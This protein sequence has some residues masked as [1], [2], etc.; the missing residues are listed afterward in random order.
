MISTAKIENIVRHI[1]NKNNVKVSDVGI[2][3]EPAKSE[4]DII[5]WITINITTDK[6]ISEMSERRIQIDI[7]RYFYKPNVVKKHYMVGMVD[8]FVKQ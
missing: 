7:D 6:Q 5:N 8:F 4:E 2:V 3:V 1:V